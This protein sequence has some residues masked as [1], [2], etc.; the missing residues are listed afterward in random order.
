MSLRPSL[1]L[2]AEA[3]ELELR[4][5]EFRG[6]LWKI[7]SPLSIMANLWEEVYDLDDQVE[8]HMDGNVDLAALHKEAVDVAN[9]AMFVAESCAARY[10][11]KR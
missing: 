1:K 9:Y 5:N 7:E 10:G 4:R 8:E 6:D 11:L 2:F 3:M